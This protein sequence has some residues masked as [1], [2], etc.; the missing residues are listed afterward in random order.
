MT[1]RQLSMRQS[2]RARFNAQKITVSVQGTCGRWSVERQTLTTKSRRPSAAVS[3]Y[4]SIQCRTVLLPRHN[5][6]NLTARGRLEIQLGLCH[7]DVY[8]WWALI[9]N[10]Q[11]KQAKSSVAAEVVQRVFYAT[12]ST[13]QLCTVSA[14]QSSHATRAAVSEAG[15]TRKPSKF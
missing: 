15:S 4:H 9:A 14:T 5:A 7:E 6:A 3:L 13:D 10:P 1:C 12:V 2:Q 11:V 8:W